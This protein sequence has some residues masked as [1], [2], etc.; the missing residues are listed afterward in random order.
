MRDLRE[1]GFLIEGPPYDRTI[2]Y[3]LKKDTK[4]PQ[5]FPVMEITAMIFAERTGMG[6]VGTPF[7]EHLRSAIRRLTQAMSEEMREFLERATEAY[8]PASPGTQ[9]LW[10]G[11]GKCS[12][13]CT[14][15]Y[16][17]VACAG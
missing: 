8:V 12:T 13:T 3:Q 1:V 11:P 9:V 5:N 7:G 10:E 17:N 6:L 4:L 2:Y 15:P 14:K 16:R